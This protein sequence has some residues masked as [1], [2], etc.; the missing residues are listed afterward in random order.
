MQ[1]RHKNRLIY[2][3]EQS[4]C[5]RKYVIPYLEKILPIKPNLR[6]LEI[7]CGEGGNL[8]PF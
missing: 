8:Q 5:T 6:I 7:G 3:Q 1:L 4:E 2:F